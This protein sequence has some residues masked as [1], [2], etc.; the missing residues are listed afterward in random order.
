MGGQEL[1]TGISDFGLH[2]LVHEKFPKAEFEKSFDS[3]SAFK[4][5]LFLLE[6]DKCS[7]QE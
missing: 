7:M 2:A 4:D 1:K 5:I 3:S 6:S